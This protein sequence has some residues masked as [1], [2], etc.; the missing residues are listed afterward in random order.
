M[1]IQVLS[2]LHLEHGGY[3]PEHHPATDVIALAGDLAPYTEGLVERLSEHWANG[4]HILYVLGNHE[5]YGTEIDE[6]R[7]QLTGIHLLDPGMI[8]IDGVRFI[9][10]TLW[11]DLLLEDVVDEVETHIRFSRELSDFRA[12]SGAFSVCTARGKDVARQ[13]SIQQQRVNAVHAGIDPSSTP[14]KLPSARGDR[15]HWAGGERHWHLSVPD[16]R[17]ST[18]HGQRETPAPPEHARPV[19]RTGDSVSDKGGARR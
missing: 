1:K 8:R 9:G 12:P 19:P 5:F 14:A 11:T 15:P 4:P 2:D 6:A 18:A 16:S 10:A 7:G 17:G 3:A 13:A